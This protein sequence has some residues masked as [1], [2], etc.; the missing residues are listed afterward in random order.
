M[1]HAAVL[2]TCIG[3]M[4]TAAL[5]G[6]I[7]YSDASRSGVMNTLYKEETAS[8]GSTLMPG[9]TIGIDDYSRGP[10]E[11]VSVIKEEPVATADDPKK[12]KRSKKFIQPP[13]PP[14]PDA[15]PP[16]PPL[17]KDGDIQPPPKAELPPVYVTEPVA[18]VDVVNET[19][20]VQPV[21]PAEVKE[22][23]WESFSRAPLKKKK[24]APVVKRKE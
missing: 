3:L 16:P 15:P 8:T 23:R 19:P 22:V 11:E 5:A 18:P 2:Y 1:K 13:P 4:G 12:K 17:I 24:T 14:V 7:D 21:P 10:L 9:K 6:F 20:V